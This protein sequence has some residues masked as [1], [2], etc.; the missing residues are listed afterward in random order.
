MIVSGLFACFLACEDDGESLLA[1]TPE[2]TSTT[3]SSTLATTIPITSVSATSDGGSQGTATTGDESDSAARGTSSGTSTNMTSTGP[4]AL[5]GSTSLGDTSLDGSG[6]AASAVGWCNLQFPTQITST[7]GEV[8]T[9]YGRVWVEG[10]TDVT[11][12]N[13][14]VPQL[15]AEFGYG[16][17]GS[18]PA[19]GGWSW[20]A[21][22]PNPGW[23]GSIGIGQENNDEYQADLGFPAG[24][25][26]YAARFSGD[27]GVTWVYCDLDGLVENGYTP[28]QAGSA[29]IK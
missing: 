4:Q 23:D 22:A 7:A 13:D 20:I 19:V 15:V 14:P 6:G 24:T 17:D 26:D 11:V 12:F 8:T 2:G 29:V 16:P 28:D 27:S 10:V 9:V 21:G 18:D 3:G 25:H 5:T 1:T